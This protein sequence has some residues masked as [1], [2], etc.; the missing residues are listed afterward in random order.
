[1]P[2][3]LRA[4]GTSEAVSA[5]IG[6]V[7]SAEYAVSVKAIQILK[8]MKDDTPGLKIESDLI[9]EKILEE[10]QMYQKLLSFLHTQVSEHEKDPKTEQSTKIRM[11]REGLIT[12][13][14]HRVDA[15]LERIFN[16]LGIHYYEQDVEPILELALKGDDQQRANAIEFIDSILEARLRHVLVPIIESLGQGVAYSE[17]MVAKLKLPSISEWECFKSL[18]TR[19]DVK[20]K[21]AVLY[22]IEQLGAH[23]YLPLI[24]PLLQSPFE[25]VRK[26]A[27]QMIKT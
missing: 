21:H 22:L 9:A 5:L 1:M 15:H 24:E 11:A 13:L 19:H 20:I 26:Q 27:E 4:I 12:I 6:F 7:D 17:D 2:D 25:S 14:K 18:L 23:K 3:V 8:M 16:L 10:C